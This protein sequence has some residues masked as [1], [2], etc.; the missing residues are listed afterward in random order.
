MLPQQAVSWWK[1]RSS[2]KR[3]VIRRRLTLLGQSV[4]FPTWEII[5]KSYEIIYF[6]CEIW[7]Q[8]FEISDKLSLFR[9]N[10][11][12][13]G[14]NWGWLVTIGFPIEIHWT[15]LFGG[16]IRG[17]SWLTSLG[18]QEAGDLQEETALLIDLHQDNQWTMV[19]A[20]A[21]I[22]QDLHTCANMT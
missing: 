22:I 14:K 4:S 13:Y 15:Y 19:A 8:E 6:Y 17:I 12:C 9:G 10:T 11:L 21:K 16:S 18:A 5:M 3:F 1:P 2:L 7:N 20:S